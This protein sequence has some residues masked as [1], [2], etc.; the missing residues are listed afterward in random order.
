MTAIIITAALA[1]LAGSLPFGLVLTRLAGKGDIRA[2]GS[3]NIGATNVLRTGSKG[4][5]LAT[6]ILDG[7][8]GAAVVM[9]VAWL[10]GEAMAIGIAGLM[11]VV[12]HC[13]PV[14]LKFQGG[15][16]VATCVAT[17]A[18][19]DIRLGLVFVALWIGTA[20]ITRYSSLAALV[21]TMG[22][23]IAAVWLQLPMPV[24]LAVITMSGISWARHHGNIGRLL[25][26]QESRIGQK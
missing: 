17:F 13:F 8:K 23:S 1:Y 3:G 25:T 20:A 5:A 26:G 15:K 14:W 9:A 18:A 12:G 2:I 6:L 7:G 4:L 21:A 16:G 11:A 10:G 22:C 24:T 19:F